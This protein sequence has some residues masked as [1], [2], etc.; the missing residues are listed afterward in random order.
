MLNVKQNT[1]QGQNLFPHKG[2]QF[3]GQ[4]NGTFAGDG[5]R[6]TNVVASGLPNPLPAGIFAG[7]NSSGTQFGTAAKPVLFYGVFHGVGAGAFIGDGTSLTGIPQL[8]AN[9]TW[10]GNNTFTG[11]FVVSPGVFICGDNTFTDP[12]I[13]AYGYVTSIGAFYAGNSSTPQVSTDVAFYG[14]GYGVFTG[15]IYSESDIYCGNWPTT[16]CFM[17]ASTGN[18]A[19]TNNVIA[20]GYFSGSPAGLTGFKAD[21]VTLP[22]T[23][24][25]VNVVFNTAVANTNYSVAI[26]PNCFGSAPT[27]TLTVT[28]LAKTGFQIIISSGGAAISDIQI[29]WMMWPFNNP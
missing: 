19:A 15:D 13:E 26:T 22:A 1:W 14:Y 10:T 7:A 16:G 25:S 8:G 9:Q 4:F 24:T 11:T 27:S 12:A 5:T 6:I 28:S 23:D 17:Q 2:N 18:I 21:V 29:A 3:W 20:E